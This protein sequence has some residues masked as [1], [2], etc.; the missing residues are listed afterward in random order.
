M[1]YVSGVGVVVGAVGS[2]VLLRCS[3]SG[4]CEQCRCSAVIM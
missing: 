3:C 1:V 2:S 4:A